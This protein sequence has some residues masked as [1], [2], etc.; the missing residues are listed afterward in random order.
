MIADSRVSGWRRRWKSGSIRLVV[1]AGLPGGHT[2]FSTSDFPE[3]GAPLGNVKAMIT[4]AKE[5]GVY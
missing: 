3:K 5:T 4:A 2:I 1:E